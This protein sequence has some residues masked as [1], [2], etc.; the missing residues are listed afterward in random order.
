M[1]GCAGCAGKPT[2]KTMD[3]ITD[4]YAFAA[5]A[6]RAPWVLTPPPTQ[7]PVPH[8]ARVVRPAAPSPAA[9]A[10]LTLSRSAAPAPS[11]RLQAA[12]VGG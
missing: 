3:E 1:G 9:A 12:S 5:A 7:A 6:M 8:H 10:A 4:E 11:V 2:A